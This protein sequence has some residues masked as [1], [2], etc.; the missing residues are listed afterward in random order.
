M[1]IIAFLSKIS[2]S[3]SQFRLLGHSIPE[4]AWHKAGIAKQ[5]STMLCVEQPADAMEVITRRC[6]ERKVFYH[7]YNT[8]GIHPFQCQLF[9]IPSTV[10]AYGWPNNKQGIKLG[11]PGIQ[12]HTNASLA[13]QL[14]RL[15]LHKMQKTNT[16]GIG[17]LKC[18]N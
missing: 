11:I 17:H 5:G 13:L 4:I 3:Q 15:W 7:L 10:D 9:V 6:Q 1:G 2:N 8:R 14:A 16:I 18:P 12:Q